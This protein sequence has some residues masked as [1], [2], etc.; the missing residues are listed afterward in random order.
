MCL[1]FPRDTLSTPASGLPGARPAS[2]PTRPTGDPTGDILGG[3]VRAAGGLPL[4]PQLAGVPVPD[5]NTVADDRS[6]H[7]P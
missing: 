6:R 2:R 7:A 5:R 4:L 1:H 3:K